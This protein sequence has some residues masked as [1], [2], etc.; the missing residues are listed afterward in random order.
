MTAGPDHGVRLRHVLGLAGPA[1]ERSTAALWSRPGLERRYPAY[2]TAMHEIVRASV[3]LMETAAL[4][5]DRTSGSLRAYLRHH[6]R[7]ERGHDAWLLEDLAA[8]G[9]DPYAPGRT[10]PRPLVAALVGAQYYWIRHYHPA[11]LLG[12]IAALESNAPAPLL[13]GR[14]AAATALPDAAFR[15]LRHHAHADTGHSAAVFDL[16]DRLRLTPP[17]VH[18]VTLSALHTVAALTDLFDTLGAIA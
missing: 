14:L 18:A 15:T 3:P 5:C 9:E 12:Y 16:L 1:L 11:C 10:P 13:A 2:L 8:A 7:E 17:Q 4:H 6:A